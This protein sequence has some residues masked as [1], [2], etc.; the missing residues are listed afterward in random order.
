M[1]AM[2]MFH[3]HIECLVR[4]FSTN[5]GDPECRPGSGLVTRRK[6]SLTG[7]FSWR[8]F[9]EILVKWRQAS[10]FKDEVWWIDLL[11]AAKTMSDRY[12]LTTAML[13]GVNKVVRYYSYFEA[14]FSLLKNL[15]LKNGYYDNR[16]V[17]IRVSSD[18]IRKQI[19]RSKDLAEIVAALGLNGFFVNV[20][21]SS[22]VHPGGKLNGTS[23]TQTMKSHYFDEN[24]L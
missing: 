18:P 3:R 10:E 4:D 14:G 1:N 15:L 5:Q 6:T 8:D 24:A 11:P 19:A 21:I 12:G 7:L 20:P 13:S 22:S 2:Q 16:E 17:L 23:S 9:F